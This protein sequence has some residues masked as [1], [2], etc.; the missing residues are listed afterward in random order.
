ML[1]KSDSLIDPEEI[2]DH[3]D[4]EETEEVKM[5]QLDRFGICLAIE[6]VLES[7]YGPYSEAA[8]PYLEDPANEESDL[9]T[10]MIFSCGLAVQLEIPYEGRLCMSNS[11][12][13]SIFLHFRD[14]FR[15]ALGMYVDDPHAVIRE[16]L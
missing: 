14:R 3:E 7:I 5:R 12:I 13:Y 9:I 4:I 10:K 1:K 15:D 6:K 2:N 11:E 8:E 16:R